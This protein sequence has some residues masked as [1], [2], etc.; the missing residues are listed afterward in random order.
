MFEWQPIDTVPSDVPVLLA[1]ETRFG[2]FVTCGVW[3]LT[4]CGPWVGPHM[5]GG[6]EWEWDFAATDCTHWARLPAAPDYD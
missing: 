6:W 3:Q 5:F 2:R 4:N 1:G